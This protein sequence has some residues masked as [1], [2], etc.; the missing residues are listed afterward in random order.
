MSTSANRD[1]KS[2]SGSYRDFTR[3]L[4][5]SSS[6]HRLSPFLSSLRSSATSLLSYAA[7]STLLKLPKSARASAL[8]RLGAVPEALAEDKSKEVRG[9]EKRR[10]KTPGSVDGGRLPGSYAAH[11]PS[12]VRKDFE[13]RLSLS[14]RMA[15]EKVLELERKYDDVKAVGEK[16][17]ERLEDALRLFNEAAKEKVRS[18]CCCD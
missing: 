3:D 9:T 5:R 12:Q 4:E 1:A 14:E 2:T 13:S 6:K 15:Q 7:A 8:T 16:D 11:R 18:C 17:K 10:K